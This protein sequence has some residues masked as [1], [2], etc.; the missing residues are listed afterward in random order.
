MHKRD[1]KWKI[2]RNAKIHILYK[3]PLKLVINP[4]K[5]Q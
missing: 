4:A 2:F 1:E 5:K 3:S